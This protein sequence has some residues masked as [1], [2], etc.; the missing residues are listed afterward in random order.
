MGLG[1]DKLTAVQKNG[2]T[3]QIKKEEDELK[4]IV[5]SFIKI[6]AGKHVGIYGQVI[7]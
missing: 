1:A 2:E 5:G 4:V 7:K 3:N 6:I